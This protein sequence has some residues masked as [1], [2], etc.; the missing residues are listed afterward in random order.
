MGK[1]NVRF[2][3]V[4]LVCVLLSG[5]PSALASS[6]KPDANGAYHPTIYING[7]KQ[8]LT[9]TIP[10]SGS[11]LV[12]FR[13]FFTA[14]DVEPQ[15][16]N[17]TKTLTAKSGDITITLTAGTKIAALNGKKVT[18]LQSPVIDEG[19]IYVNLRFIAESFGGIV[20]FDQDTLTIYINFPIAESIN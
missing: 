6:V 5:M 11:T 9:G 4:M 2:I 17:S 3:V 13:A 12:P 20:K 7:E 15:F 18:L 10:P 16:D 8:D 19:V 1:R 14:L